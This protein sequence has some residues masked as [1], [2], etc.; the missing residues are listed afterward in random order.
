MERTTLASIAAAAFALATVST[1]QQPNPRGAPQGG[2]VQ[3]IQLSDADLE[4][5]AEIYVD[6]LV[7]E[8]KFE[9]ELQRAAT[10]EQTRE[11][12]ARMQ[13]EGATKLTRHGWTA[14]RY[15]LVGQT[16]QSDPELTEK[17]LALIESRH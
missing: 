7:T 2:Q 1:A 6:L 16:I 14:E 11:V 9:Q 17:T 8:A 12:Q 15:V 13:Q 4:K 3:E 10:E 5:F